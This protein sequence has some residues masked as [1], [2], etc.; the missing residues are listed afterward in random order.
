MLESRGLTLRRS[1][2]QPSYLLQACALV[3]QKVDANRPP[4]HLWEAVVASETQAAKGGQGVRH[5]YHWPGAWSEHQCPQ[6]YSAPDRH[7]PVWVTPSRTHL[8]P[9]LCYICVAKGSQRVRSGAPA[10]L[11]QGLMF[12]FYLPLVMASSE[13]AQQ[14]HQRK[15]VAC[16]SQAWRT[17]GQQFSAELQV[18]FQ[19]FA[20]KHLHMR[21]LL[22]AP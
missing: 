8:A 13:T 10:A 19:Q 16:D 15:Q 11:A 20:E 18:G 22:V 6:P 7:K 12:V 1:R 21:A 2:P 5:H 9:M 17:H 3:N 14:Q 4:G